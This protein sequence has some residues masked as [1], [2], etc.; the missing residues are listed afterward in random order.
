M[1]RKLLKWLQLDRH[2]EEFDPFEAFKNARKDRQLGY[3]KNCGRPMY[4]WINPISYDVY[5]GLPD[6]YSY[7]LRC[8]NPNCWK[9]GGRYGFR[10]KV[11]I[12]PDLE[13]YLKYKAGDLSYI[14]KLVDDGKSNDNDAQY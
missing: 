3:C 14:L 2:E 12:D 5:T 10:S 13:F 8:D 6:E 1:I 9:D 4:K 11:R 7:V